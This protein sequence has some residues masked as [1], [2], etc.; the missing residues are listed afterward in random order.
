MAAFTVCWDFGAQENKIYHCFHFSPF[1]LAW[2]DGTRCHD[3]SVWMLSFKPAFSLS[4]STLIK[5]LFSSTTQAL[6]D[7]MSEGQGATFSKFQTAEIRKSS[8]VTSVAGS[9]KVDGAQEDIQMPCI[10]QGHMLKSIPRPQQP[11]WE[12][13]LILLICSINL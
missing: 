4:S 1:Y 6:R 7:L 9:T 12:L 2:S 13:C 11:L 5:R 10:H 3:L 8:P